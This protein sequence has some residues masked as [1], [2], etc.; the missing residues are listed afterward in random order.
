M[1]RAWAE[2][3]GPLRD[4]IESHGLGARFGHHGCEAG[5]RN[6]RRRIIGRRSSPRSSGRSGAP[7]GKYRTARH[8]DDEPAGERFRK[9]RYRDLR[10]ANSEMVTEKAQRSY[11]KRAEL[12]IGFADGGEPEKYG[13]TGKRRDRNHPVQHAS[14]DVQ[15]LGHSRGIPSDFVIAS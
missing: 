14:V 1:I 13:S 5:Y 6:S 3:A 12:L 9:A 2:R 8:N 11:P 10:D 7:C 15:V 4:F